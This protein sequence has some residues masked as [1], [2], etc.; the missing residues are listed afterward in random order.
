MWYNDVISIVYGLAA[1]EL[2][3]LRW[4]ILNPSLTQTQPGKSALDNTRTLCASFGIFLVPC[5]LGT[6]IKL[7]LEAHPLS[8]ISVLVS[9]YSLRLIH[10]LQFKC[11]YLTI[12]W[13][14]ST[15]YN[16][17]ASIRLFLEAHPLS[18]ISV[19]VSDYSF[20]L[21]HYLQFLCQYPTIPWGSSTLYNFC[22]SIR[23]FLEAHPLST[24]SVLVSD[25][26]LR[27]IHYL[28]FLC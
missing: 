16:F 11:Q 27:L 1:R 14:S 8:T 15:I 5:W 20:R 28:R 21:I 9:D 23:L 19:P 10:Y 2:C 25:Y 18:T 24:T 13:G 3:A 26:S 6:S 17:C 7:F 12:P 4:R 22:A